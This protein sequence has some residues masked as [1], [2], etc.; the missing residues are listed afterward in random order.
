MKIQHYR[1]IFQFSCLAIILL[2]VSPELSL[3]V[4]S[5]KGGERFSELWLLGPNHMAQDYPFNVRVGE[6]YSVYLGLGNH[7]GESKYYLV[8]AK[9]RNQTQ[10]LPNATTSSPS[11]LPVQ[12]ELRA[13]V[14]DG[15]TWEKPVTFKVLEASR[16]ENSSTVK[17][18][19][20]DNRDVAVNCS[21][22]WDSENK[23]FRFELFFELWLYNAEQSS[24]KFHNRF[25]GLWLNMTA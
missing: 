23:G 14:A 15:A 20:I 17:R 18:M 16:V 13:I 25:V 6:E 8:Y 21:A 3:V 1:A 2:A 7:M 24:F 12:Y 5:F 10:P 19:L 22:V 11:V 4:S 9:F